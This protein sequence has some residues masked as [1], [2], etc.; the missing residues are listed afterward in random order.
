MLCARC[1]APTLDVDWRDDSSFA[2][3]STDKQIFVCQL[4]R[5]E[6][7]QRFEGHQDEVNAVKWDPAGAALPL[8]SASR[9]L[10][11]AATQSD[12]SKF[13]SPN[14]VAHYEHIARSRTVLPPGIPRVIRSTASTCRAD[15]GIMFR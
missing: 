4:G 5:P 1:A 9:V 7:L 13:C 8:V 11:R 3:C 6:P 12:G 14:Q 10:E 2:S 15:A